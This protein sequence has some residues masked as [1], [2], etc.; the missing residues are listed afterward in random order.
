MC[1]DARRPAIEKACI[2]SSAAVVAD[3]YGVN[4]NALVRHL[5][6]HVP[7]EVAKGAK[8]KKPAAKPRR[9]APARLQ[10][11][12]PPPA[13]TVLEDDDEDLDD[14]LEDGPATS[15][16]PNPPPTA[17]AA[18]DGILV[19]IQAL[20]KDVEGSKV[21]FTDKAAALRAALQAARLLASLTGELGAT[22]STVASSPYFRRMLQV[23][24]D[25][26]RGPQFA[27]ARAAILAALERED[28][29]AA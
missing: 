24:L 22:E 15:R 19:Q 5:A 18:L 1:T 29:V 6:S 23:I 4:E 2:K 3:Q 28:Q 7:A 12:S 16:S 9:V 14:E 11:P 21:P 20:T 13:P 26:V 27:E 17:R 8:T 25:A 10:A